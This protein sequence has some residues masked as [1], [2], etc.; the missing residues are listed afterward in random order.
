MNLYSLKN[1]QMD[2]VNVKIYICYIY[3]FVFGKEYSIE[4]NKHSVPVKWILKHLY[5]WNCQ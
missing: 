2:I 5:N 4:S 1:I 3:E